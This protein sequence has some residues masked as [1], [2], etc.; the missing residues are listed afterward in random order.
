[1]TK[2]QILYQK[3]LLRASFSVLPFLFSLFDCQALPLFL[4]PSIFNFLM[5]RPPPS[6][7]F[8]ALTLLFSLLS[9]SHAAIRG[10]KYS[11]GQL[12]DLWVNK[13]GPYS[14]PTE[15]YGFFDRMPWCRPEKLER[16]S[17][18]LG[19]TLQGDLLVRSSYHIQFRQ[20][21]QEKQLCE[22]TLNAQQVS[23]FVQAIRKRFVYDFLLDNLPMKLFIGEL[24]DQLDGETFLFTH[25]EFTVKVNGDRV[26]EAIAAPTRPVQLQENT[27]TNVV[28]SY[29]VKWEDV[30]QTRFP[31]Q[32]VSF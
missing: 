16:R 28:F 5:L 23:I 29:S 4:F 25:I 17:L 12:L 24:N 3:T 32:V 20:P 18:K 15:S 1:M 2:P 19:E 7:A 21:L 9:L 31:T 10:Q 30:R 26:I 8:M 14:S 13:I 22:K 27:A 6:P 11:N